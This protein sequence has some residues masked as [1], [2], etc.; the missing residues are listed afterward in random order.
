MTRP[1]IFLAAFL[2]GIPALSQNQTEADTPKKCAF[3]EVYRKD[4]WKIPGTPATPNTPLA[5]EAEARRLP[6]NS[7]TWPGVTRGPLK[8]E[9]TPGVFVT[10]MIPDTTETTITRIWCTDDGTGR[11]QMDEE[12]IGI[13]LLVAYDFEGRTFA[14]AVKYVE[15]RIWNGTRRQ[16][17]AESQAMFYDLDG[18]GRF[19]LMKGPGGPFVPYF[20][21]DWVK[22]APNPATK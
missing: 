2:W 21:P 8:S 19:T 9:T 12:P 22:K 15:E 6:P 1:I 3:S 17:G 18:S 13:V 4:G 5:A 14:Y 7:E 11:L 20:I 10:K 16:L